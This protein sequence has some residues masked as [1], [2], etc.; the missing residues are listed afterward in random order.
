LVVAAAAQFSVPAPPL[1]TTNVCVV[2]VELVVVSVKLTEVA[3]K[4][5]TGPVAGCTTRM[6]RLPLSAIYKLFP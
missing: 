4:V 3:D 5:V 6:R 2:A 1:V